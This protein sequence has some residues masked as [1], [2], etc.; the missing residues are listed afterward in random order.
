MR[1]AILSAVLFLSAC[2]QENPAP[3]SANSAPPATSQKQ[4]TLVNDQA[5]LEKILGN[6]GLTLQW[7]GWEKR[8]F[9]NPSWSGKTLYLNGRQ[10]DENG[11]G[12]LVIDGIVTQVEKDNFVFEGSIIIQNTPDDGRN[13][14]KN[15]KSNFA[16]TQGRKYFRMREFEYCDGLTDYIDIYF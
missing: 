10:D 4:P 12:S 11:P 13:C 14:V 8:G 9:I 16:I 2:T 3:Q 6:S 5:T 1:L 15:G 7:I